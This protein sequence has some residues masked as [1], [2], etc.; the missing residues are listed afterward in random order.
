MKRV[1][2]TLTAAVIAVAG[3]VGTT[4]VA[5]ARTAP[6]PVTSVTASITCGS[7]TSGSV[8]L[9]PVDSNDMA[10]G[11]A[12]SV[13]CGQYS[14]ASA[15][16]SVSPGTVA[17][18][19]NGFLYL[20]GANGTTACGPGRTHLGKTVSCRSHGASITFGLAAS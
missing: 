4:S 2:P 15:A 6:P 3:T 5:Y 11:S 14:P 8:V 19:Y 10:T 20:I 12:F 7:N 16:E 13:G 1:A 9:V 18:D 17:Y